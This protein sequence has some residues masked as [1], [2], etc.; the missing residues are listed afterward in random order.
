MYAYQDDLE[1]MHT[2]GMQHLYKHHIMSHNV[3]QDLSQFKQLVGPQ[4]L[5]AC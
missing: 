2:S 4:H 5:L 1:L 3:R